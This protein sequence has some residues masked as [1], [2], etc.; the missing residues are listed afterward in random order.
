MM[1][2]SVVFCTI[3]LMLFAFCSIILLIIIAS[4]VA[5]DV[6]L[7]SESRCEC[8]NGYLFTGHALVILRPR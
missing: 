3:C 2:V 6:G 7:R 4:L 1:L 8:N 5:R